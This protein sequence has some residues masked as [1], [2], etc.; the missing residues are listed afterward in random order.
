M[1]SALLTDNM[2]GFFVDKFSIREKGNVA[3]AE[4]NSSY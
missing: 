3:Y 1:D 4:E 2:D